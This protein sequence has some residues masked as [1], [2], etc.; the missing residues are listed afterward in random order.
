MP[1]R[2]TCGADRV[3]PVVFALQPPLASGAAASLEHRLAAA[4][5]KASKGGA[6][7]ASP[8]N[9]PDTPATRVAVRKTQRLRVTTSVRSDRPPSDNRT[10]R[11]D[12]DRQ[13]VLIAM[14][15]NTDH[16]IQLICNH[17][18]DPPASLVGSSG[19]GLSARKP[20]RQDCNESRPP[21]RTSS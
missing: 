6:V 20:Q 19:A 4:T 21:G 2:R 9:R 15:V 18:S 1:K 12:N 7:M 16:V 13:H 11:R 10:R 17:A 14:R 8:L 3:E 5:Q